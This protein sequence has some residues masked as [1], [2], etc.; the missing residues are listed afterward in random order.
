MKNGWLERKKKLIQEIPNPNDHEL[1]SKGDSNQ[2]IALTNAR[3]FSYFSV[4]AEDSYSA[5]VEIPLPLKESLI[6]AYTKFFTFI[7]R[8]PTSSNSIPDQL[9]K[10]VKLLKDN[11]ISDEEFLAAKRK[12]LDL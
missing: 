2:S 1:L 5:S 9:E 10:L 3:S 6:K 7:H 4:Y 12:I 8:T 11:K